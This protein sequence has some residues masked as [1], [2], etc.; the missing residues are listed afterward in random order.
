METSPR[1]P[2]FILARNGTLPENQ[3]MDVQTIKWISN[4]N[5][6]L[7][8]PA[9]HLSKDLADSISRAHRIMQTYAP[10]SS[11]LFFRGT[12]ALESLHGELHAYRV[13][14][15]A[16]VT[17]A[18]YTD[19]PVVPCILAGLYH[20]IARLND[21]GDEGHGRRAAKYLEDHNI[22]TEDEATNKK[23]LEAISNHD[24]V[25]SSNEDPDITNVL[26]AADA[27]DRYRLPKEKWWP[28]I[29]LMPIKP[30]DELLAFA[31]NLVIQTEAMS[32]NHV[33]QYES[34]KLVI[35]SAV[36]EDGAL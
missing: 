25:F 20:D 36:G 6:K 12:V 35:N 7:K 32:I 15:F 27:L 18:L 17:A 21:R 10:L 2:L 23:I 14:I 22:L 28:D 9:H 4:H 8:R 13:A 24:S 29:N 19:N 11:D 30:S 33:N 26:K 1:E 3:Y 31:Y 16:G 5:N 34:L